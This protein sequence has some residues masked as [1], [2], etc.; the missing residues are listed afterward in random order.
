MP[1]VTVNIPHNLDK[2]AVYDKLVPVFNKL[3]EAFEGKDIEVNEDRDN[4]AADFKFKS[5]GFTINGIGSV[6]DD[7]VTTE[8]NLPFA[9]M[10]FK[11][12][13]EKAITK[14]VTEGLE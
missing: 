11:G 14:Y 3:I 4:F 5:L 6:K 12:K 2:Q 9:A 7:E 13:V 8:V 1:K 10:M